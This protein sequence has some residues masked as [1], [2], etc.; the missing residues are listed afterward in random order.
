MVETDQ[1]EGESPS[2]LIDVYVNCLT[3]LHCNI[4]IDR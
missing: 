4:S 3:V 2:P 1:G